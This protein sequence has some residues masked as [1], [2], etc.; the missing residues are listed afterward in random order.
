[1]VYVRQWPCGG[2]GMSGWTGAGRGTCGAR[3]GMQDEIF[4]PGGRVRLGTDEPIIKSD[5]EGPSFEVDLAPFF[6]DT[7][8]VSNENFLAFVEATQYKTEAEEF[9]WSFAH[10]GI[11]TP[12]VLANVT[13]MVAAVPWWV[14]V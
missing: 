10:E 12:A 13:Q 3:F 14:P 2:E 5:A 7:Y 6:L 1:M 4:V 8:E 9:G 11:L